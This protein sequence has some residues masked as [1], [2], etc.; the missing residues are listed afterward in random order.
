VI[1]CANCGEQNDENQTFCSAP[2]C[3]AFLAWSA[4]PTAAPPAAPPTTPPA[5]PAAEP[6][7][8][9]PTTELT[10]VPADPR[11]QPA[12]PAAPVLPAAPPASPASPGAA[13]GVGARK[14]QQAPRQPTGSEPAARPPG[15]MVRARRREHV[16]L[17]TRMAP[18]TLRVDPGAETSCQVMIHNIGTIVDEYSLEV[19]GQPAAWAAVEPARL[20]L[21]PGAQG[22]VRVRFRPPRLST[23]PSG[24]LPF[25]VRTVSTTDPT[26]SESEQ[27][28]LEVGAFTDL[29]AELTP[30]T[31]QGRRWGTHE[32]A[33]RSAGNVPVPVRLSATDPDA[34][35]RFHLEPE[36]LTLEPGGAARAHVRA[37]PRHLRWLG[38]PQPYPFRVT[39]T[40]E[41]GSALTRDGIMRQ[42]PVIPTWLPPA[43][44]AAAAAVV[45]LILLLPKPKPP[46]VARIDPA[47]AVGSVGQVTI[48]GA[49]FVGTPAAPQVAFAPAQGI[50]AKVTATTASALALSVTVDPNAPIINRDVTVTNPTGAS[51]TCSGCFKVMP[52]PAQ[53]PTVTSVSPPQLAPGASRQTLTVNGTNFVASPPPTVSFNPAGIASVVSSVTPTQI[54]LTVSVDPSASQGDRGVTVTNSDGG[55]ASCLCFAIQAPAAAP[56]APAAPGGGGGAAGGGPAPIILPNLAGVQVGAATSRLQG[57]GLTAQPVWETTGS[58]P[59]GAVIR[60]EPAANSPVAKGASVTLHLALGK[61]A[62]AVPSGGIAVIDPTGGTPT[63][64]TQSQ[65]S[66]PVWSPDGTRI[67]FIRHISGTQ[68]AAGSRDQLLVMNADGRSQQDL[69]PKGTVSDADPAWS[70]NGATLA[71]T[72]R[73]P[74]ASGPPTSSQIFVVSAKP[75]STPTALLNPSGSLDSQPAWSPDG[76]KMAFTRQTVANGAVATSRI[77]VLPLKAGSSASPILPS[78]STQDSHPAWSPDGK[79]IAFT[80]RANAGAKSEIWLMD[81]ADGGEQQ[82]LSGTGSP[83]YNDDFAVWSMDGTRLAFASDRLGSLSLFTLSTQGGPTTSLVGG[84]TTPSW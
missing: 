15:E 49:N 3:G 77:V 78:S 69:D 53:R 5:A 74:A 24:S 18:T 41:R 22:A 52:P 68:G 23:T 82:D 19:S 44:V 71:F 21:F 79:R 29:S 45:A 56:A 76:S 25:Q 13:T 33:L 37:Q 42:N 73:T 47:L 38:R 34:A 6:A 31:S 62:Y 60:T 54:S 64:L 59:H 83:T 27:G 46:T 28:V 84:A 2:G 55:T 14:P 16:S 20:S 65:D 61:V 7:T 30:H 35:L 51:A 43:L 80:R 48:S 10:G 81:A 17:N 72:R 32:V 57:L 1:T 9:Q 66:Q 67:A 40:P 36:A 26:V 8:A 75:G 70:P 11:S 12:T 39:A 4:A 58:L 63:I 50:T